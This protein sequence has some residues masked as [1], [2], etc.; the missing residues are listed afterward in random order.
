M[1]EKA[2]TFIYRGQT[3]RGQTFVCKSY[4][5]FD[6]CNAFVSPLRH[7]CFYALFPLWFSALATD[8]ITHGAMWKGKLVCPLAGIRRHFIS[9]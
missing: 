9:N 3:G 7:F 5:F 4:A 2:H 6:G 1:V 8:L